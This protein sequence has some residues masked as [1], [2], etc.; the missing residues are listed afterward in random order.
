[1]YSAKDLF[2]EKGKEFDLRFRAKTCFTFFIINLKYSVRL[3]ASKSWK[4][5]HKSFFFGKL[6]L[7]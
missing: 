5:L 1:M 7:S 4:Y 3:N 6:F 2:C